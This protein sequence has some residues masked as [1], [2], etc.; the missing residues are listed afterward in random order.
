M[1]SQLRVDFRAHGRV[2]EHRGTMLRRFGFH[3]SFIL[4]SF[5]CFAQVSYFLRGKAM[6]EIVFQNMS[7]TEPLPAIQL[8]NERRLVPR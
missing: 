1:L 7:G 8:Q 5:E 3:N 4:E 6:R 2:Q